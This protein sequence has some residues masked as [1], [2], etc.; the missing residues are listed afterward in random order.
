MFCFIRHK[1]NPINFKKKNN[2]KTLI[3]YAIKFLEICVL[4]IFD[5][6]KAFK[7]ATIGTKIKTEKT[8]ILKK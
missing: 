1:L 3:I 6:R 4:K 5:W 7:L 8:D 2:D